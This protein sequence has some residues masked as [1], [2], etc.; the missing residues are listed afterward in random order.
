MRFLTV[1]LLYMGIN[2][3]TSGA[4]S[5]KAV[6]YSGENRLDISNM[7]AIFEDESGAL[8]IEDVFKG[9]ESLPFRSISTKQQHIPF[10]RSTFWLHF[11]LKSQMPSKQ[12][13]FLEV[14]NSTVN[15]LRFY[16]AK[17]SLVA[18]S[19]EMGIQYPFHNRDIKVSTFMYNIYMDSAETIDC[20]IQLRSG[21]D[22][23]NF[24]IVLYNH[25][26]VLQKVSNNHIIV[27][28]I[29][30]FIIALILIA[31]FSLYM[32]KNDFNYIY[33]A[34]YSVTCGLWIL[35]ID[36]FAYNFLWS[37][38]PYWNQ[39]SMSV[40]PL[41]SCFFFCI[42]ATGFLNMKEKNRP[43]YLFN[44]FYSWFLLAFITC[45]ASGV[46][47]F[48]IY[49]QFIVL[50]VVFTILASFVSALIMFKSNKNLTWY[51]IAANS[52][53]LIAI[54]WFALNI[55][56]GISSAETRGAFIK[57]AL[58]LQ[59]FIMLYGLFSK[60]RDKQ[61][62]F[63]EELNESRQQY[64][65]IL[66]NATEAIYILQDGKIKFFNTQ[67]V[68]FSKYTC[69]Q[70][71]DMD[72]QA[73]VHENE[74]KK[75]GEL[76]GSRLSGKDQDKKIVFRSVDRH[77]YES[78]MEMHSATITWKKN[79]ALLIFM[80]DISQTAQTEKDKQRLE[81]QLIHAQK[82]ETIGT[83]AGGIAHDFNNIL[84][85][86]IGYSEIIL[87]SVE[88]GS[89]IRDDVEHIKTSALRAKDLVKQILSF[90]RQIDTAKE[91]V[92]VNNNVKEVT[93]LMDAV[94]PSSISM[95]VEYSNR[96]PLVKINPTQL[97]Q[98]MMNICTNAFQAIKNKEGHIFVHVDVVDKAVD[99]LLASYNLNQ[100]LYVMVSVS[101]N[102]SGI[103]PE[104]RDRIFDPFFTTKKT[105]EGT[106]LGLSVAYGIIKNNGG[107]ITCDSTMGLG[108]TF[109]IYLPLHESTVSEKTDIKKSFPCGTD[110]ILVVDDEIEI[111]NIIKKIVEK[112]GYSVEISNHSPDA[113]ALIE[114]HPHRYKIVISDITM[115]QLNGVELAKSTIECNPDQKII[116]ISGYL[117]P[118][119]TDLVMEVPNSILLNKPIDSKTLLDA[120]S[121][122]LAK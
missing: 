114:K 2:V 40:V 100:H 88:Q 34:L 11:Q 76:L 66:E 61:K 5:S 70:L 44:K 30:G 36:G 24:P 82:L 22:A 106:G 47:P 75:M 64:L 32:Q 43:T 15:Y 80:N 118:A 8:T 83:L 51:Y 57:I 13:V 26:M 1:L 17:D 104:V 63:D 54:L 7:A 52:P 41:V 42:F 23:L 9:K 96:A 27:G 12:N 45:I 122:L 71:P 102:G 98:V 10:S 49:I 85:P 121:K 14:N 79:P 53:L 92:N 86:I 68:I 62:S 94:L 105:G 28:I 16:L 4:D 115:P 84:T 120:I 65:D 46:I 81:V 19:N 116:F 67:L 111:T 91:V 87:E 107:L 95:E 6:L 89:E 25:E 38:Y 29:I 3:V 35:I 110:N 73:I 55:I 109:C 59:P 97:H 90:S 108:S 117:E 21:G 99:P 119:I 31:C 39:L 101:D 69:E 112:Q 78:L 103:D 20:F 72:F 93:G 18:I 77:G 50:T 33:F 58:A 37:H 113:L 60:I 74:R 56:F 48:H